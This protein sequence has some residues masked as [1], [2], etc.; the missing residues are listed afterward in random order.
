MFEL[1]DNA[2]AAVR[3]C[4]L[5]FKVI[6]GVAILYLLWESRKSVQSI[7]EE[8]G[9]FQPPAP[10]KPK[11][12]PPKKKLFLSWA[13]V[14]RAVRNGSVTEEELDNCLFC[15]S[16]AE[17][18]LGEE[19]DIQ[20][21]ERLHPAFIKA[22]KENRLIC[23]NEREHYN[24]T[25]IWMVN[26][27]LKRNGYA[28]L[29]CADQNGTLEQIPMY[30]CV[31]RVSDDSLEVLWAAHPLRGNWRSCWGRSIEEIDAVFAS[32]DEAAAEDFG[33]P[34]NW[35]DELNKPIIDEARAKFE[36]PLGKGDTAGSDNQDGSTIA[37]GDV[38][39]YDNAF[40][41]PSD[42]PELYGAKNESEQPD[43]QEEDPADFWKKGRSQDGE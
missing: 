14:Q 15:T 37:Y 26:M 22:A 4:I 35:M 5:I 31:P 28:L 39:Q 19:Y 1:S 9:G 10:D 7:H 16:V 33:R 17:L 32:M 30:A 6:V 29:S 23:N 21:F 43:E 38:G 12:D 24:A 40:W 3:L 41:T 27:L 20:W 25:P 11:V 18:S 42:Y 34:A 8:E 2:D 13:A 36:K